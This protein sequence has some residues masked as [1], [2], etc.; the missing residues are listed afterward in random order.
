MLYRLLRPEENWRFGL[1]STNPNSSTSVFNYVI[2]FN[3]EGCVSPY[4]LTC[5]SLNSVL[6]LTT[7]LANRNIVQI[8]EDNL[9][10]VKIDLR[11]SPNRKNH[12]CIG[13]DSPESI[14]LFNNFAKVYEVVLLVGHVPNTHVQLLNES[15]FDYQ[16]LV[17]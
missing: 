13:Y 11:T 3:S 10:V 2:N 15:D 16:Q 5:G 7:P 17:V 8:W 4:I 12:Y 9:P 1:L 6:K 14:N